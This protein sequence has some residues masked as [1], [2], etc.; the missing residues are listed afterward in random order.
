MENP[1]T[2]CFSASWSGRPEW[3]RADRWV[4]YGEGLVEETKK[5]KERVL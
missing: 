1:T 3:E 4:R 5:V 2:L